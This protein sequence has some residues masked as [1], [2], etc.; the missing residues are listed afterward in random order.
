[1]ASQFLSPAK[2]VEFVWASALSASTKL[3]NPQALNPTRRTVQATMEEHIPTSNLIELI[4]NFS[5]DILADPI[6]F[7]SP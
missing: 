1:M 7:L 2:I 5:T 4:G 3:P 6:F